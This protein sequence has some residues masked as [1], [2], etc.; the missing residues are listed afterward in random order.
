MCF[1]IGGKPHHERGAV[2]AQQRSEFLRSLGKLFA[3][4][5]AVVDEVLALGGSDEDIVKIGAY[6]T[7]QCSLAKQLAAVICGKGRVLLDDGP[8]NRFLRSLII[9]S[10][11]QIAHFHNR[12]VGLN[13]ILVGELWQAIYHLT[14]REREIIKL[15]YGLGDGYV[16]SLEETGHIFKVTR[17]RIRQIEA[18]A[19]RKLQATLDATPIV[20]DLK[21]R[22]TEETSETQ[23]ENPNETAPETADDE[24]RQ[25]PAEELTQG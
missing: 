22:M 2:M 9:V 3:I 16:Y 24:A 12:V 4:F 20:I 14:Y 11:A 13:A 10:P 17:E 5:K 1:W 19:L 8:E 7:L 6:P 21:K 23:N 18:K 25:V 15:R